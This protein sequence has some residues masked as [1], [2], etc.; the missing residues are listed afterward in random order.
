MVASP[1]TP[2][3]GCI[4][5]VDF[6]PSRGSEQGKR[7]PALV[8]QNNV[9]NRHSGTTIVVPI[10]SRIPSKDYPFHV[11]LPE[12][13]ID[14]PGTILCEQIRTIDAGRIDSG[15]IAKCSA[16]LMAAVAEALRHSL[17]LEH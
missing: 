7:R 2:V 11:H 9:G 17:A 1:D 8:V 6:S 14:K 12:G 3:R 16:G 5:W 4:Y 15:V 10:T 13:V